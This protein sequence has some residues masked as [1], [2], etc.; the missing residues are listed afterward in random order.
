MIAQRLRCQTFLFSNMAD[1]EWSCLS[2]RSVDGFQY[3][4]RQLWQVLTSK[5]LNCYCILP[6][7]LGGQTLIKN[8]W[9]GISLFLYY[10]Y[11]WITKNSYREGTR[12]LRICKTSS[13]QV[14]VVQP[15]EEV[16][17]NISDWSQGI[18]I[19]VCW[20]CRLLYLKTED[21]KACSCLTL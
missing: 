9:I 14:A 11:G 7:G 5:T 8:L 3:M 18:A 20:D 21:K 2:G 4:P 6:V 19:E 15:A 1:Q 16:R 10:W 13:N 17:R 12:K